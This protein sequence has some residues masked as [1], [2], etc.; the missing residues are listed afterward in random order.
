MTFQEDRKGLRVAIGAGWLEHS[1]QIQD[2][3]R[4]LT[5]VTGDYAK[6][7]DRLVGGLALN[8]FVGWQILGKLKRSNFMIGFEFNQGFTQTRRDWDFSAMRKLEEKRLDLRFG[9][10]A[11]WTIPF[12]L[13]NSAELF[14]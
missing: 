4:T 3:D 10:K 14:Y 7:Y 5:Q 1:I 9:I 12:Y 6:G 13:G 11:A 8:E 2:D